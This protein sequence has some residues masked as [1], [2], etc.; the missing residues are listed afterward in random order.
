MRYKKQCQLATLLDFLSDLMLD[1]RELCRFLHDYSKWYESSELLGERLEQMP[2]SWKELNVARDAADQNNKNLIIA[3]QP[4][5]EDMERHID[6]PSSYYIL[7]K[8]LFNK[9]DIY[10]VGDLH[11]DII[12]ALAVFML[13]PEY[14]I[15]HGD[16]IDYGEYSLE[17]FILIL[18]RQYL[19]KDKQV[20]LRG[21]HETISMSFNEEKP[22]AFLQQLRALYEDKAT[23][24]EWKELCDMFKKVFSQLGLMAVAMRDSDT[25]STAKK[26]SKDIFVHGGPPVANKVHF[27]QKDSHGRFRQGYVKVSTKK[28]SAWEEPLSQIQVLWGDCSPPNLKFGKKSYVFNDG[29][30]GRGMGWFFDTSQ[31]GAYG[32][33]R[34]RR[35]HQDVLYDEAISHSGR[36]VTTHA[37]GRSVTTA[38]RFT[39]DY[40]GGGFVSRGKP[41]GN[42]EL[43]HLPLGKA[44]VFYGL[45]LLLHN[46]PDYIDGVSVHNL[47]KCAIKFHCNREI[48]DEEVNTFVTKALETRTPALAQKMVDHLECVV[49][50]ND[51]YIFMR[52]VGNKAFNEILHDLGLSQNRLEI[53]HKTIFRHDDE[54]AGELASEPSTGCVVGLEKEVTYQPPPKSNIPSLPSDPELTDKCPRP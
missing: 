52:G 43:C 38:G 41:G 2:A 12:A 8:K 16:Y 42:I 45:Y 36:V 14:A 37:T 5:Y 7:L 39:A 50:E 25:S 13:D 15:F 24:D 22:G 29:P 47:N 54:Y 30:N 35:G 1:H 23:D 32:I 20:T 3:G 49:L 10:S 33:E 4:F 31:F 27:P 48:E 40:L 21:N 18:F 53:R 46:I 44:T 9:N 51:L 28:P 17:V 11:G 34:V 6:N 19:H 26:S